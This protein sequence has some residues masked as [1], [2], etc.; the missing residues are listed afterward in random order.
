MFVFKPAKQVN[1]GILV[2]LIIAIA[3]T[4]FG[5]SGG[6][7]GTTASPVS[8][9]YQNGYYNVTLDYSNTNHHEVGRQY[10]IAIQ[11]AMPDYESNL[12]TSLN[13][14]MQYLSQESVTLDMLI[15]RA[16]AIFLNLDADYQ[17]EIRGMQEVFS[18]THNELGDGRISKDEL[19]VYLLGADVMRVTSCSASAAFGSGTLTGTAIVGR[20]S[21]GITYGKPTFGKM[22]AVTTFKNGDKTITS[23][24]TLG[25]LGSM[26][27]FNTHRMFGA[28]LDASTGVAYPTDLSSTRS[29]PF[30]LRHAFESYSTIEDVGIY[31]GC[32]TGASPTPCRKYAYNHNIFL[33]DRTR[34]G[35]LENQ[36]NSTPS[37]PGNRTIRIPTSPLSANYDVEKWN[38]GSNFIDWAIATVNDY[39]LIGNNFLGNSKNPY[40]E[41]ND[42]TNRWRS[43]RSCFLKARGM[44]DPSSDLG[45]C[46]LDITNRPIGIPEMKQ[47]MGCSGPGP[48]LGKQTDGALFISESVPYPPDYSVY[49]YITQQSIVMDMNSMELWV[50]LTDPTTTLPVN[51]SYIKVPNPLY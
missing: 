34:A 31:M 44:V 32:A 13:T 43:Y 25:F 3:V 12:D 17:D 42:D 24:G 39:R 29:Y 30:D 14:T 45:R 2:A 1:H 19:L 9:Q 40:T 26:S 51:P 10:A 20:N 21:D 33:A 18:Y 7:S 23:I 15:S 41:S 36:A 11:K 48:T 37:Y 49:G 27:L 28:I 47:I 46:N 4:V 16:N 22:H 50:Y 35:V 38:Y 6:G 5:C 8:I